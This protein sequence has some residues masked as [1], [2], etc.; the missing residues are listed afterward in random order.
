LFSLQSLRWS[1]T[2]WLV[3][4]SNSLAQGNPQTKP[5]PSNTPPLAAAADARRDE[6]P[7][8]ALTFD[9]LPSHGPLPPGMSR[10]DI[11]QSIIHALQAAQ[12]PPTYGFVNAKKLGNDPLN[13]QVLQ[14]WRDAGFPLANHTF[15]HMD[16]N[17]NSVEDFEQDLLAN[18][19]TLRALMGDQDWHWLR[20]PYL[21][22]GDTSAKHQAIEAFLKEHKYRVA[23]VTLSFG[24]YD[25]NE[26]Y[27]RCDLK[28]DTT[29]IEQPKKSYLDGAAQNLSD[30]RKMQ[31]CSMATTSNMS[32]CCTS[33]AFKQ[34]CF[35][36]FS[37]CSNRGVSS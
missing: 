19:P 10:V 37:N 30:G 27:A 32:C 22:E 8:V 33:E 12:V 36:T 13:H 28:N 16:L 11:A 34:L 4:A 17:A 20:F 21:R 23:Q 2:F 15:T 18:E 14:L 24:D 1:A 7:E 25:Y 5:S 26:P 35:R 3:L 31:S 29:A 6:H 9:D